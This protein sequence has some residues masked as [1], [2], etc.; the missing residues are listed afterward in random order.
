MAAQR[1]AIVDD[2][3][4]VRDLL[5]E[6]LSFGGYDVVSF[7]GDGLTV[8]DLEAARPDLLI[9]DLLLPGPGSQMNGWDYLRLVRRHRSLRHLPVLVCSADVAAIRDRQGEISRDPLLGS[10]EKPFS[11]EALD[12]AVEALIG[13]RALPAWDDETDLVLVADNEAR[14]VHASDAALSVLGVSLAELRQRQVA[15]IVAHGREWTE[16]EWR[17]YMDTGR[18]TGPVHL[19]TSDGRSMPAQATAE[20][21]DTPASTW[22]VSR[23]TLDGAAP[24]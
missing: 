19:V 6:L 4:E 21:F 3:E 11:V 7:D 10:L 12:L 8:P 17:R 23:L 2:S 18:W 22:H 13:P 16:R 14:L 1:I 20:I 15:D 24:S 9:L 5:R